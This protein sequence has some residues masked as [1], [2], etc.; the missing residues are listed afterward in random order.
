MFRIATMRQIPSSSVA[1]HLVFWTVFLSLVTYCAVNFYDDPTSFFH[2]PKRTYETQYSRQREIEAEAFIDA[3]GLGNSSVAADGQSLPESHRGNSTDS[4]F[5]CIGIPSVSR[6][7]GGFIKQTVATLVDSLTLPE[8]M[9][10]HIVVLL[11][12]NPPQAHSAYNSTWLNGLVDE[13]L[14]YEEPAKADGGAS[15]PQRYVPISRETNGVPRSA[16]R[17]ENMRLDH[18]VL[19][20]RCVHSGAEYFALVEDDVVAARDW[21]TKLEKGV[22]FVERSTRRIGKD[23]IYLRLFY[24][25][26]FMGWNSEELPFYGKVVFLMY[27]AAVSIFM[28]IRFLPAIRGRGRRIPYAGKRRATHHIGLASLCLWLVALTGL[29]F[30]AGRASLNRVNPFRAPVREMPRYGCCAQ[31]LVFPRRQLQGFQ[32]L[33]RTPPFLF[34]GD[35]ILEDYAELNGLSKWALNP[36]VLQHIGLKQSSA[37]DRLA[38][39]WNFSFERQQGKK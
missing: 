33:L 5:L 9:R 20:E 2:D 31:G 12:N 19:V 6:L 36:S 10:I 21:F 22:E 32:N 3:L 30:L 14:V 37:G 23:W 34:A 15:H 35:Q 39:V 11:A 4:P 27:A 1:F 13:V 38:E 24:S 29:V 17:L 16:E 7:S 18:S 26:M 8:R 28:A 25:E